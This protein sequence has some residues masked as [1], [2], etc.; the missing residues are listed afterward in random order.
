MGGQ[1]LVTNGLFSIRRPGETHFTCSAI[2][3]AWNRNMINEPEH[4]PPPAMDKVPAFGTP[5]LSHESFHK[6]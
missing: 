4:P 3:A 5:F 1:H 2:P 6:G